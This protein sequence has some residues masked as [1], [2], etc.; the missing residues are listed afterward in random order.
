VA[1]TPKKSTVTSRTPTKAA[2][3]KAQP[4][5]RAANVAS[6]GTR[7]E[8]PLRAG[9]P[10]PAATNAIIDESVESEELD[11]LPIDD[12]GNYVDEGTDYGPPV[13]PG[14]QSDRSP[15]RIYAALAALVAVLLVA[16][17]VVLIDK[18]GAQ[19]AASARRDDVIAAAT[20]YGGYLSSYSYKNLTGNGSDWKLVTQNATASFNK[21]FASTSGSLGQLLQQYNA[22]ATGKVI[23]AGISSVTTSKAVVLLFIDQTVTNS[24]NKS[25]TPQTQ[26]LRVIL[27]LLHQHGRWLIDSL[28]LPS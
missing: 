7:T 23:A 10:A 22:T 5:K 28:Q 2:A 14:I 1:T 9:R 21:D 13:Y 16:A 19:S 11:D 25:S 15:R 26:P 12:D 3:S 18:N 24:A 8:R 20:K 6:S 4:G 27:T 17:L